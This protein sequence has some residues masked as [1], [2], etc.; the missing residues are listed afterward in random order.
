MTEKEFQYW[1]AKTQS[2]SDKWT[3]DEIYRLNGRGAFYYI[4]GAEK[5]TYIKIQNDGLVEGGKYEDAFPHIGDAAFYESF[6]KQYDT[7]NDAFT[8]VM[9]AAGK[10]FLVD[11]FSSELSFEEFVTQN[12]DGDQSQDGFGMNMN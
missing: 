6:R 11:M 2:S 9:E 5:G 10:K 8:A 3:E 7:F 1:T 4:G 12:F